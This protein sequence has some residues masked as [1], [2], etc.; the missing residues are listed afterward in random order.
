MARFAVAETPFAVAVIVAV[1]G[2]AT[3]A[4]ETVNV[5]V[6]APAATVTVAGTVAE[7]TLDFRATA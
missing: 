1:A 3:T 7:A 4:V 6:V 2:A 5:P